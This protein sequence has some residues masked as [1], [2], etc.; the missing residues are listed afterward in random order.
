MRAPVTAI[1]YT[2]CQPAKGLY[3]VTLITQGGHRI[4]DTVAAYDEGD[5]AQKARNMIRA[6]HG[7]SYVTIESVS[8][9]SR[10]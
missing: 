4:T 1:T 7:E 6:N 9:R 5:A 2:A 10:P 8:K 3:G